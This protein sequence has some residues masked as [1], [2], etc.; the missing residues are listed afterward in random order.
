MADD[1]LRVEVVGEDKLSGPFKASV[2]GLVALG[3]ALSGTV[4]AATELNASMANVA[5]LIP[6]Q[7]GR[8]EELRDAVQDLSVKYGTDTGGLTDALYQTI[9]AFGDSA[10]TVGILDTATKAATAGVAS[11]TDAINLLSGVTKGYGDTSAAAVAKAS[12][13]ATLTVRLG[14]TTFPELAASMGRVVPLTSELNVSQEELF[15]TMATATGV[16]GNAAE[17]STQL[18]GVMQALMAPTGSMT[19]LFDKLGV[20]S[21]KALIEQEGL[22]GALQAVVAAAERSG[23]PLQ[24]YIGSIE[25]QTIALA[26]TGSQADVYA[27][28]LGE[29]GE[30][31]GT[32]DEA[33][34]EQTEGVNAAG[35]AYNQWKQFGTTAIQSI[36]QATINFMGPAAP[37]ALAVADFGGALSGMAP[38]ITAAWLVAGPQIKAAFTGLRAALGATRLSSLAMWGALTGGITIAVGLL[39]GFRRDIGNILSGV[40]DY[41]VP[42]AQQF[43]YLLSSAVGFL[44]DFIAGPFKSGLDAAKRQLNSVGAAASDW[45]NSWGEAE[46]AVTDTTED[47]KAASTAMGNALAPTNALAGSIGTTGNGITGAAEDA[48]EAF[49]DWAEAVQKVDVEKALNA[50]AVKAAINAAGSNAGLEWNLGFMGGPG[51][52]MT[53]IPQSMMTLA[54]DGSW[55]VAGGKGGEEFAGGAGPAFL[56]GWKET[57]SAD[58]IWSTVARAFEG[59]GGWMGGIK[60]VGSQIGGKLFEGLQAGTLGSLPGMMGQIGGKISGLWT[61]V[62]SAVSAIPFAGPIL[63]A[64]GPKILEGLGALGKKVWGKI[65]SM[66]GGPSEAELAARDSFAGIRTAFESEIGQLPEY[67]EYVHSLISQGWDENLAKVKAGFDVYG[68]AAGK[69]WGEIGVLYGQLQ[70]AVKAGDQAAIDRIMAIVEEWKKAAAPVEENT[71]AIEANTAAVEDNEEASRHSAAEVGR[72]FRDLTT[73][74]AKKL[75]DAL[76]GLGSKANAAFTDMHDSSLAAGNAVARLLNLLQKAVA[77]PWQTSISVDTP[78]AVEARAGGGPVVGGLPVLVGEAG[79]EIY[80]PRQAGTIIPNDRIAPAAGGGR[81][82]N[83]FNL[84]INTDGTQDG[85]K[86]AKVIGERLPEILSEVGVLP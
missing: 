71:A 61:G 74:E 62:T 35:H 1:E 49:E 17:V 4:A 70:D 51:G 65:K 58:N 46:T 52:V 45:T 43:L 3:G 55:M 60:S 76:I 44:P 80:V 47:V 21:G 85:E 15:A 38:Q 14:Q 40:I 32:T 72:Q 39:W 75:G 82:G 19:N 27:E 22:Q 9:S 56:E 34:R 30:A 10:D 50:P 84:T 68:Q 86:V 42:W 12:D 13:L 67:Q 24:K 28:K 16:T 20:E 64:F 18:K 77:T 73:D 54:D 66:F 25:G 69:T 26:L 33:L 79:P 78:A 23:D 57:V 53:T 31:A 6:G 37:A 2:A 48:A 8:V 36:G 7:T 29:M 81:G 83:V 59:G 63:A 5:S 41:L 11:Q